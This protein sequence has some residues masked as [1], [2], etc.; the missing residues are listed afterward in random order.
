MPISL[1]RSPVL[2][3]IVDLN[4][5]GKHAI[6]LGG[7]T[8]GVRKVR[9]LLG[10]NCKITVI[11]NRLNQYLTHLEK[12]GKIEII[13]MKLNDA[14]ILNNFENP[15]LVLAAT[16][17]RMLNRRFVEKG[18]SIGSIVYSA[19]D[20]EFS[21]F[22][23]ASIIN[24]EGGI[25]Q[26]AVSTNGRSPIMARKVRIKLERILRGIIKKSDIENTKLQ[27]FARI[28]AKPKLKTVDERK[29]FLYAIIRN[30]HIQKLISENKVQAAKSA[31]LELLQKWE[32]EGYK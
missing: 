10:Q 30:R 31:T 25:M 11:S 24:V 3:L 27:E 20:P 13:K 12:Q 9:G 28:A 16:P 29:H 8:E 14:S 26:V 32:K 7:G 22:S 21:D 4:L 5:D 23:Y 17:D 1:T 19:D 15:F 6:V 2:C 18:R